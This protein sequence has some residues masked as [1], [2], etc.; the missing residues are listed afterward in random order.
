MVE[1]YSLYFAE[2]SPMWYVVNLTKEE[3]G[4]PVQPRSAIWSFTKTLFLSSCTSLLLKFNDI[5][6]QLY[7]C[8]LYILY[9]LNNLDV[10]VD[11]YI[12]GGNYY[13]NSV[14]PSTSINFSTSIVMF[15]MNAP[16][17]IRRDWSS[18]SYSERYSAQ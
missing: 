15:G 3:R 8:V 14:F 2:F 16:C 18:R 6:I 12:F 13:Y 9:T 1:V 5:I 7:I 17:L 11:S 4:D 10:V